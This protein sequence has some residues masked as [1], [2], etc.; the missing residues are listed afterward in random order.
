MKLG[1]LKRNS[2]HFLHGNFDIEKKLNY[3]E[4][5]EK[6]L[7]AYIW[8]KNKIILKKLLNKNHFFPFLIKTCPFKN[9]FEFI[10]KMNTF[11]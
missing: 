10:E 2:K 7:S 3:S 11:S 4:T 6:I 5:S 1:I 9:S 8:S